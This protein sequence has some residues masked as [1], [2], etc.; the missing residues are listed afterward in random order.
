MSELILATGDEQAA[1]IEEIANYGDPVIAEIY[2]AWR[3]GG[4]YTF[5]S[6][7]GL[8][9]LQFTELQ[10]WVLV[11]TGEVVPL[12]EADADR[13]EKERASRSVRK[14]MKSI[15]D[16]L[17]LKAEDANVRIDSA[18]K[19]GR[20]QKMEF[21]PALEARLLVEPSKEVKQ[22]I[23]EALAISLLE[24]GDAEQKLAAVKDLT[25][26]KSI[27]ARGFIEKVLQAE[28]D[29]ARAQGPLALASANALLVIE[30]H[31]KIMEFLG[32]FFR[33]FSTGSVLLIVSFGL[34]ITFGLMGI[35]NMAHG[36]FV[37]IG[38]YTTYMV[39]TFFMNQWGLSSEAF[40]WYFVVSLP[41]S[42]LMAAGIGLLLEKTII[43]FL[44]RR[45]LESLLCTWGISMVMQQGFRLI[46]GAANVQV[47]NPTWL[48]GNLSVGGFSMS[49]TRLFIMFVAL[50]VVLLTW[51]LL[52][53][54]NLGLHIRAVMQNRS[55]A[56]SLGIPVARVNSMTF[57]LGCGLAA[58]GGSVLSQIGNVGPLMGQQYIVD[59]FMVVVIGSVG[60]LLG[61]GISAMGIGFVDQLLQP[62]LGPVMGKITVFFVIILF[63]QWRPGGLFPT[64]SR[65][66]DD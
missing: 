27:A 37:A 32:S 28:R 51:L 20:S 8:Q 62:S 29:A 54:T 3:T 64:R 2:E 7:T 61:A 48:M 14:S 24:N 56:S 36:E 43:R 49:Y 10:E 59:S 21:V 9:L 47:N 60:N 5:E 65:S 22:A 15:I 30:E 26:M 33:G 63:L 41:L 58:L 52:R 57:A 4:V 35:I 31:V 1:L 13:V 44:Y 53:K 40:G 34:A 23:E 55:M 25:K 46:F 42:F 17:G 66:L 38:G 18:I 39:Q 16:T 50:L 19:M 12:S 11:S 6:D 45:P